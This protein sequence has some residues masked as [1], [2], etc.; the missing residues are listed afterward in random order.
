[1][2]AA[3]EEAACGVHLGAVGSVWCYLRLGNSLP[4]ERC[5][6][7]SLTYLPL[8]ISIVISTKPRGERGPGGLT[9]LTYPPFIYPHWLTE[10]EKNRN[11]VNASLL[12]L[13]ERADR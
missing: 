9:L 10:V 6:G 3:E 13:S 4:S 7:G 12:F 1:M 5:G 2:E 8:A 11:A